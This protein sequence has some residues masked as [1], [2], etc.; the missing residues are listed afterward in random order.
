MFYNL[1][2]FVELAPRRVRRMIPIIKKTLFGRLLEM[3][4]NGGLDSRGDRASL[5]LE[6][7]GPNLA[8][9]K[10][11]SCLFRVRRVSPGEKR[12]RAC[13][14][15]KMK[16]EKNRTDGWAWAHYYIKQLTPSTGRH[17]EQKCVVYSENKTLI[18]WKKN[19]IWDTN[20]KN[21]NLNSTLSIKKVFS[22]MLDNSTNHDSVCWLGLICQNNTN[23]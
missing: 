23:L 13:R 3:N 19:I 6:D 11:F 2:N 1:S 7:P 18:I 16:K 10:I 9:I 8:I 22:N 4:L 21:M 15:L 12:E 14:N 5:S 17:A 20:I